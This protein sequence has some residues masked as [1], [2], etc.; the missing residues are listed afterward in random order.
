MVMTD[1][2]RRHGCRAIKKPPEGLCLPR[3]G[4]FAWQLCC[5]AHAPTYYD[6]TFFGLHATI[7]KTN[8]GPGQR[9]VRGT[10]STPPGQESDLRLLRAPRG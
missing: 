8:I 7:V 6:E 3:M 4:A 9:P 1:E 2:A 10:L 5:L